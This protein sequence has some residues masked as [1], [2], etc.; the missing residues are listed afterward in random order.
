VRPTGGG[1][2]GTE[3]RQEL[4]ANLEAIQSQLRATRTLLA[5]KLERLAARI[6]ALDALS[7]ASTADSSQVEAL[8]DEI[9]DAA[10][11]LAGIEGAVGS[12]KTCV[13]ETAQQILSISPKKA[14][15]TVPERLLAFVRKQQ[16]EVIDITPLEQ[17]IAMMQ[18]EIASMRGR[19]AKALLAASIGTTAH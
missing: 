14:P 9:S 3:L 12:M 7:V 1:A 15:H 6:D 17:D 2:V 13:A 5:G 11:A 19:A 10:A 18:E 8:R 16:P 4:H